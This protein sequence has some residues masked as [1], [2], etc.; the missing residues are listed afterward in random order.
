[1]VVH[2][3]ADRLMVDHRMDRRAIRADQAEPMFL[4]RRWYYSSVRQ[5]LAF[6]PAVAMRRN[7]KWPTRPEIG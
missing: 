7:R 4:H 6:S 5:R 3:M 2:R 1:M